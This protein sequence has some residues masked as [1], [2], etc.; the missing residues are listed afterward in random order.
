MAIRR[1]Y[2]EI[3]WDQRGYAFRYGAQLEEETNRFFVDGDIPEALE[4]FT[5][6]RPER[7]T[8]KQPGRPP[9]CPRC[10][11]RM[12]QCENK[13][14][15]HFFWGC[16]RYPKCRTAL[17]M[18]HPTWNSTSEFS[19]SYLDDTHP[20]RASVAD[21]IRIANMALK[22]FGP[23]KF[24]EWLFSPQEQLGNVR[25]AEMLKTKTG[26]AVVETLLVRW[27]VD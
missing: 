10:R 5:N 3:P 4:A 18:R 26:V 20:R 16:S 19:P 17:S 6:E 12:V 23:E 13:K 21:Y 25:P 8:L 22:K 1:F 15:G 27:K 11:S 14:T 24:E 7:I 9:V 2:L